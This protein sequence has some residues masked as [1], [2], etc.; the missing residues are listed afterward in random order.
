MQLLRMLPLAAVALGML[1]APASAQWDRLTHQTYLAAP[2]NLEFRKQHP[3]VDA[4]FDASELVQALTLEYLAARAEAP[5][6]EHDAEIFDRLVREVLANAGNL[7]AQPTPNFDRIAPQARAV[8]DWG[9]MLQRQIFDIYA[10]DSVSDRI[11]A[12]DEV[13]EYYLSRPELA[14]SAKPKSIDL[15]DE[16]HYSHT[17]HFDYQLTNGLLWA[18]RWLQFAAYEPLMLYATPERQQEGFFTVVDRF[19]RKLDEVPASFPEETPTAPA[20]TPELTRRHQE[21]AIILDNLHM[22]QDVVADILVNDE[23]TDKRGAIDGAI[24]A[25]ADPDRR[26]VSWYDWMLTGLRHG[27]LFQGGPALGILERSERN[28]RHTRGHAG[29]GDHADHGRHISM[30]P[31]GGIMGGGGG[32]VDDSALPPPRPQQPD[33]QDDHDDHGGHPH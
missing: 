12:V 30:P 28:V 5:T 25:F 3:E 4:L 11:A 15:M 31:G 32:M 22:L 8:F 33:D 10:D 17:F 2:H 24:A 9:R 7:Q 29:H 18:F 6:E 27:I 14:V 19:R 1:A 16:N 26:V 13:V 20:I 23:V 21:A